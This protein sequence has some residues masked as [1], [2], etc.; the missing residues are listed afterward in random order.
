M[1]F[2]ISTKTKREL[3]TEE[4]RRYALDRNNVLIEWTALYNPT[5]EGIEIDI[6]EHNNFLSLPQGAID[7]NT[8]AEM[9]QNSG[10]Y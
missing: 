10:Y 9:L 7:A 6:F 5:I 2:F 8:G 3:L 1:L 4:H